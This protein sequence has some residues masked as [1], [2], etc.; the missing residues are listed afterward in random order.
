MKAARENANHL[1]RLHV[2]GCGLKGDDCESLEEYIVDIIK[3]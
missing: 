1:S 3:W 2:G